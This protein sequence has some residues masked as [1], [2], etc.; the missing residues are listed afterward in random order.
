M[1]YAP[2]LSPYGDHP[3]RSS[4][5]VSLACQPVATA[6]TDAV[7]VVCE[8]Y[9]AAVSGSKEKNNATRGIESGKIVRC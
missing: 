7:V 9:I 3:R 4:F 1:L 2:K 8:I 6:K 5:V